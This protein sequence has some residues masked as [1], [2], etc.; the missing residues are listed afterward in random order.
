[1]FIKK[2]HNT[3]KDV[4][5]YSIGFKEFE[6]MTEEVEDSS[7]LHVTQVVK[8]AE[9]D[10]NLTVV[11]VEFPHNGQD[12]R[13][14]LVKVL[15]FNSQIS[16]RRLIRQQKDDSNFWVLLSDGAIGTNSVTIEI[17]SLIDID[18]DVEFYGHKETENKNTFPPHASTL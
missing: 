12:Y 18:A 10:G 5:V 6:E 13:I 11:I 3:E 8:K 16:T 17:N 2:N 4:V 7:R 14:M 1:M 15:N 9:G